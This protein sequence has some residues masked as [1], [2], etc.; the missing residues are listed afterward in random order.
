MYRLENDWDGTDLGGEH[1]V[2]A[3]YEITSE[4]LYDQHKHVPYSKKYVPYDTLWLAKLPNDYSELSHRRYIE[5]KA[6]DEA[7]DEHWFNALNPLV[8]RRKEVTI[9]H[10]SPS[11]SLLQ[12]MDREITSQRG[13]CHVWRGVK[14]DPS[15]FGKRPA[16]LTLIQDG[17][18]MN[19]PTPEIQREVHEAMR[20]VAARE[21]DKSAWGEGF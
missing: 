12:G 8:G 1:T 17:H 19:K 2:K 3:E 15:R 16:L 5:Q 21:Y 9:E 10:W 6:K 11:V 7:R 20:N 4:V 13:K 14:R 18:L